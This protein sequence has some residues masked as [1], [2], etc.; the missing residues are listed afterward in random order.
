M[1]IACEMALLIA[2]DDLPA[3]PPPGFPGARE[4]AAARFVCESPD[5]P[6]RSKPQ[7]AT[8]ERKP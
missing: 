3:T 8:D 4:D 6:P 7:P 2:L 5:L 1:C